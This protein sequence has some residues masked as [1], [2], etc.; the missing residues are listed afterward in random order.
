MNVKK[1]PKNDNFWQFFEKKK[2]LV[3]FHISHS[4][5]NFPEGQL[6]KKAQPKVV[7][8][9]VSVVGHRERDIGGVVVREG[10]VG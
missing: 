4:N 3:I 8:T 6:D 7:L 10:E 9:T 2:S 1:L 5:S